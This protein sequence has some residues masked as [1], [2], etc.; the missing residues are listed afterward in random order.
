MT[1][2]DIIESVRRAGHVKV[3]DIVT[4]E[5]RSRQQ[6]ADQW[7]RRVDPIGLGMYPQGR[8][9]LTQTMAPHNLRPSGAEQEILSQLQMLARTGRVKLEFNGVL[10][11]PTG[12]RIPLDARVSL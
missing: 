7:A 6:D 4:Q 1:P 12:Q 2:Q 5:Q 8:K 10:F 11:N 9:F 3:R